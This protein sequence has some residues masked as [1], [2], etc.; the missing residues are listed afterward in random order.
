MAIVFTF[1]LELV[2]DR[3]SVAKSVSAFNPFTSDS[4]KSKIVKFSKITYWDKS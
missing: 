4:A 1:T 3:Y 2:T